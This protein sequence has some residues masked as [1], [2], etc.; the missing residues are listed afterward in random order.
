MAY[1]ELG[2]RLERGMQQPERCDLCTNPKNTLHLRKV[3]GRGEAPV[4]V[5]N[6]CTRTHR[7]QV[8]QQ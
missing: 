5:C 7:R 3:G 1:R 8:A 2:I 4:W 6:G